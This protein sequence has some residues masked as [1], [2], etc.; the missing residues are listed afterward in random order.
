M[1]TFAHLHVHSSYS[2]GVGLSTPDEICAHAKRAGFESVALTDTHGTYGYVEFHLAA[3]R[4]GVKPIYGAVVQHTSAVHPADEHFDLTL[5]ALTTKGLANVAALASLSAV[6]GA[7]DFAAALDQFDAYTA[8][9]AVLAGASSSEVAQMTLAGDEEGACAALAK[10]KTMFG[11]NLYVELQDYESPKA[12]QMAHRL[13][14]VAT[15]CSVKP[16]LAEEVRYVGD[17]MRQV[18]SLLEGVQHPNEEGDFFRIDELQ[19]DRAMRNAADMQARREIFPEAYENAIDIVASIEGDL[20]ERALDASGWRADFETTSEALH[21]KCLVRLEE[22]FAAE[23]AE[24]KALYRQR[25]ESEMREIA[26]CRLEATFALHGSI[27]STM[28]ESRLALGPST[29]LNLQSLAA[30]LLGITSYEPYYYTPDFKPM[31]DPDARGINEIE[32]QIPSEQ[33][34]E[35]VRALSA[36]DARF[37][38][39]YIPA[40]ERITANRA[41][42]MA[43]RVVDATDEEI[44]EVQSIVSKYPGISLKRL[45]EDQRQLSNLYRRSAAVREM[46]TRAIHLEHLPCGFIRSKR[47]LAMARTPLNDVFGHTRDAEGKEVFAQT[48]RDVIPVEGI[49]RIDFTPLHALTIDHN[50]AAATSGVNGTAGWSR[51]KLDDAGVWTTVQSGDT[52]GVFLF[53]GLVIQ[54]QRESFR[55]SSLDD[56]TDFLAVLRLRGDPRTVAQRFA[57]FKQAPIVAFSQPPE[58]KAVTD[59]TNGHVLYNEQLRELLSVI[60]GS[61]PVEALRM[62]NELKAATPAGLSAVRRRYMMG[63]ADQSVDPDL[64]NDWFDRM[65]YYSQHSISRERVLADAIVAYKLFYL[66]AHKPKQFYAALLNTYVTNDSKLKRYIDHLAK[67]GMILDVDI[68]K[69]EM[70]F[71]VEGRQIRTGLLAVSGL[72]AEKAETV[73]RLRNGATFESVEDF[74]QKAEK[75]GI[76]KDDVRRLIRA[77][78]FDYTGESRKVLSGRIGKVGRPPTKKPVDPSQLELP[79]D[80]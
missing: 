4:H 56:L 36:A 28:R 63:A 29:G 31:F 68:N 75:E 22:V 19:T 21:A 12:K 43:A 66:K 44:S 20:F 15:E 46:L 17:G 51:V 54:Q 2:L 50:V 53:E 7:H 32:I 1:A 30:Y 27:I 40:V 69:S 39:A 73:L 37:S 72:S 49:M 55:L 77:G 42:R 9:V 79:F 52:T 47:S 45:T 59:S 16:V 76:E 65:L 34:E 24:V 58:L 8:D 10:L 25:L 18:H 33:R 61:E 38:V 5:L 3:R 70:S 14:A 48:S 78:A 13:L 71:T 57:S 35:A 74:A 41:V 67:Q 80:A 62:L 23:P 60:T 26:S 6:A 11:D 64:A